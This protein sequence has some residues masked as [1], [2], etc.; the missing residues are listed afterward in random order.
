MCIPVGTIP[1]M[2]KPNSDCSKIL[3]AVEAQPYTDNN[4]TF[5]DTPGGVGV[6]TLTGDTN[7]KLNYTVVGFEGF[8]DQ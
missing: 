4:G 3:I 7:N 5:V 1:D 6:V 2:V 8:D